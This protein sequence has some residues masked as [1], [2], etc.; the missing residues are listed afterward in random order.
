VNAGASQTFTVAF[1]PGSTGAKTATISITS[2]GGNASVSATGT[3]TTVTPPAPGADVALAKLVVP[4]KITVRGSRSLEIDA[5]AT[6]TAK[7]VD[8]TVTLTTSPGAGVTVKIDH[9]SVHEEV[10]AR[11]LKKFGFG[12]KITCTKRGTWPVAWTAKISAAQNSNPANDALTGTTQ[13][14]C[15]GQE[16]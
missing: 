8:A 12:A 7:E 5:F 14:T 16:D 9:A 3:G 2:N 15:S 10:K 1:K 11:E 6:T 4:A 13:V